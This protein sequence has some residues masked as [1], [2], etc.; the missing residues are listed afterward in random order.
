MNA[1]EGKP[2]AEIGQQRAADRNEDKGEQ[3][4]VPDRLQREIGEAQC[5]YGKEPVALCSKRTLAVR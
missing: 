3:R 5:E 4:L 2:K 1:R